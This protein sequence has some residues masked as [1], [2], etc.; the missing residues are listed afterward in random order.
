MIF[1]GLEPSQKRY[2]MRWSGL[3]GRLCKVDSISVR[4]LFCANI[5][6]DQL[7]AGA[8]MEKISRPALHNRHFLNT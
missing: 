2:Q 8:D 3:S 6:H 7:H 5:R 4:P 1:K